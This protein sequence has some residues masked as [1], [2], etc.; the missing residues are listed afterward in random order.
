MKSKVSLWLASLLA[1]LLLVAAGC[2][3]GDDGDDGGEG[4]Q[5]GGDATIT[6]VWGAEPPSLDPGLATDT[7]SANV[8]YNIMDPLVRLEGENLE[9]APALAESWTEEEG[10]KVYVFK[11]RQDGKW[12]NG[13]PVTAEDFVYSWKR[14]LSPELGADYA[15][16]LYGI[17][18]A[19][20][21]NGCEENCDALAD[22]VGVEATDDHTLRV[23]LT[24]AQPWFPQLV[25]H[26]SF[27][28]V[29]RATVEQFGEKWTEA[30]NIVT[31]GPYKL[32][33]WQHESRID[34]EKW[35][36]WRDADSVQIQRIN[37]RIITEGTTAV[38]AF[39]AGEVDALDSGLI[40][41]EETARWKE[42][43]AY[44]QSP[45]LGTYYYG[46]NIKKITDVNQRRAMSLAIN[47]QLIVDQISQAG[48][49]PATGFTPNGIAGFETI[50]PESPWT[51]AEGD[52]DQAKQL[53]SQVQN[54]VT[55]VQLFYNN[56]PG[57][58]E[59]AEAIQGMWNELGI[60]T[61]IKQQEWAQFLEFL[62]PP[63]NQQV[64]VYR[65]GWIYDYPDAM[66]GLEL[67]TCDSGN[68]NT[69]WCNE[70]FD[71]LVT[72]ARSTPDNDERYGL[73][74][75]ME[76]IA[77]GDDGEMPLIPIYW[78][79]NQTLVSERL[80][81]SFEIDPQTFIHFYKMSVSE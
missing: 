47:R 57:H 77:F 59:I 40:P 50:N 6:F 32:A 20:E 13:D 41:T 17:Q 4:A 43:D 15:Y 68:N 81:D 64:D 78:Y 28:A 22:Q 61:T 39:E 16:Q 9:P 60:Q 52:I 36:E 56:A 45:A 14:T 23:T 79:T 31:N 67:W 12:T 35:P 80:R 48:E 51:P 66:N 76:E 2:G 55:S 42:D 34:M 1:V 49:V 7:T 26:H 69:N 21:Y 54:P 58:K 37:G 65:L 44:Y 73:Y 3:G 70:E 18:G 38:Q 30:A 29:H 19:Q 72:D 62:G 53:M 46:F 11:L 10:G 24:S 75:Q 8:L 71:Q 74:N 63:P 5:G 25:A 27:L 33:A